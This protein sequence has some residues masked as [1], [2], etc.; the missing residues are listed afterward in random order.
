LNVD[1][2]GY[3]ASDI[4]VIMIG[5]P[6]G[7]HRKEEF[8]KKLGGA[9]VDWHKTYGG[10]IKRLYSWVGGGPLPAS[11]EKKDPGYCFIACEETHKMFGY[12]I[13]A[14]PKQVV[15]FNIGDGLTFKIK[16]DSWWN[17]PVAHSIRAAPWFSAPPKPEKPAAS[18]A[19]AR[20]CEARKLRLRSVV[21]IRGLKANPQLNGLLGTCERWEGSGRWVVQLASGDY[22]SVKAENL[23]LITDVAAAVEGAAAGA[24][25]PELTSGDACGLDK[26]ESVPGDDYGERDVSSSSFLHAPTPCRSP[27][28]ATPCPSGSETAE[29]GDERPSGASPPGGCHL[30]AAEADDEGPEQSA[31]LCATAQTHS[32]STWQKYTVAGGDGAWWHNESD[33]DWFL[34]ADSGPWTKYFDP[35]T[36]RSYWWKA[37]DKWFFV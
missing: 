3:H 14:Y 37:E 36:G 20:L 21:R 9:S 7:L 2:Q 22:K 15:G 8:S 5:L 28:G 33:G 27:A 6:R 30:P 4:N 19:S 24:D 10:A 25:N 12:D 31:P 17:Y 13:W 32:N 34:E 1:E 29:T 35:N 11:F 16:M 18:L 26:G 23:E